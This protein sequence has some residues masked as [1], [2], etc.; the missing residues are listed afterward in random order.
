MYPLLITSETRVNLSK[1][2]DEDLCRNAQDGCHISRD[3]LWEKY[4]HYVKKVALNENQRQHLPRYEM[5]DVLQELYFAFYKA[6]QR[7]DPVSH[8]N[9]KPATFKTFLRL[10]VIHKFSNYCALS[11]NYRK[12]AVLNFDADLSLQT[13]RE[14]FSTPNCVDNNERSALHWLELLL[15]EFSCR[16]VVAQ[17]QKLKPKEK[18][19]LALWLQCDFD[20]EVAKILE[21]SSAAAKLRRERLIVRIRKNVIEE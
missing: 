19:L 8:C 15:K 1:L 18:G 6:V 4:C 2:C 16:S 10:V 11:R 21:I 14:Y 5:D 13:N 3:L 12:H 17:L 9:G 20:K 7:Y